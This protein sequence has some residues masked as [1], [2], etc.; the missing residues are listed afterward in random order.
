MSALSFPSRG[1]GVGS[2][3]A[4][5]LR[6]DVG[7]VA[8]LA[9]V[10]AYNWWVV[11]PFVPGLMTSPNG[12]FSDLE[13][14]GMRDAPVMQRC[15]LVAGILLVGAFLL[16]GPM[17]RRGTRPEWKWMVGFA[18]AGAIGGKYSYACSEGL[19]AGCRRLE[20]HLQLPLHHYIHVVSGIA[21]FAF[22]TTAVVVAVRRTR[23]ET[24][25]QARTFRLLL[26]GLVVGYPLLGLVYLT[27]RLGALVE[28]VFFIIFSA[29]VVV[30]LFEPAS[31]HRSSD[32]PP[33]V[34]LRRPAVS[35]APTALAGGEAA[36]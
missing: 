4:G 15:D 13:A 25:R 33:G 35:P 3:G 28:P 21:E 22:L 14:T 17:G 29:M 27:D 8:G 10:A 31:T 2:S 34:R 26:K 24:T 32:A 9:G 11:V 36:R 19:S 20:W 16:R 5:S 30:E 1:R 12:F 18:A 6:V 23:G 7:R